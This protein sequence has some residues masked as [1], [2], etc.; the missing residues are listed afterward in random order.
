MSGPKVV[1]IGAGVVGAATGWRLAKGGA[2]VTW[3]DAG[4]AVAA[5]P[6]SMA[7]INAHAPDDPPFFRLRSRSLAMWRALVDEIDGLPARLAGGLHWEAP[8]EELERL[9][10]AYRDNG[11]SAL[12]IDRSEISALEP[13]LAQL[14]DAALLAEAEGAAVPEWIAHAFIEAGRAVGATLVSGRAERIVVKSGRAVGVDM[15]QDHI[16]ADAVVVAAGSGT[17]GLLADFDVGLESQDRSGRIIRT[18]PAPRVTERVMLTPIVHFWQ[19]TDG[20]FIAGE[21]FTGGEGSAPQETGAKLCAALEAL[22][23]KA[24]PLRMETHTVR[25]R[26]EP[27]DARPAVGQVPGVDGLFAAMLHSGVTFAPIVSQSLAGA[28]LDGAGDAEFERYSL[29]RFRR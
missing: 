8:R 10:A 17:P 9:G 2:E 23:P 25:R 5:T 4:S 26:P 19:M 28:V 1:V 3:L 15:D 12:M 18:N 24:G 21:D 22:F 11:L 6:G 20:R 27:Q 13:A 16:A 29:A 14:P 7:W